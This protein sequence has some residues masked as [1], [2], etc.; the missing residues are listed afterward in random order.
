M[1]E[2]EDMDTETIPGFSFTPDEQFMLIPTNDNTILVDDV[3]DGAQVTVLA[4]HKG[5]ISSIA[6]SSAYHNFVSTGRECLFWTV[7]MAT[8]L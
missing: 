5:P 8:I 1:V 3:R 2:V 6:F 7:D 4:G